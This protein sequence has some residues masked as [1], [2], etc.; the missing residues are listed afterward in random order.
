MLSSFDII[1]ACDGRMDRHADGQRAIAR[2]ALAQ[3]RQAKI[4]INEICA[5]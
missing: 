3:R 4:E 2:T 1:P 5:K